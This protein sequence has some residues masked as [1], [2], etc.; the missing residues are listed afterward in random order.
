[1]INIDI[2]LLIQLGNF[3]ITLLIINYLIIKP[4]RK[5]IADRRVYN[6][7]LKGDAI[8]LDEEASSKM[9]GYAT[10]LAQ[11][12]AEVASLRE[13]VKKESAQKAQE[14]LKTAGDEARSIHRQ[15]ADRVHA[16]SMETRK[17]LDARLNNFVDSAVKRILG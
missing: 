6:D 10:R 9:E 1:M 16:E 14:T 7:G 17:A 2:T 13:R 4:I 12:R 8:R 5:V 11:A 15:A 3:L